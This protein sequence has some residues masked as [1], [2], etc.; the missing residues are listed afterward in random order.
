MIIEL[1]KGK[2]GKDLLVSIRFFLNNIARYSWA[3]AS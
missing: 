3:M 1:L 2:K